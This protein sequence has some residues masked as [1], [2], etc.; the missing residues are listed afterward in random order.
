MAVYLKKKKFRGVRFLS[1]LD[2]NL[3]RVDRNLTRVDK[4]LSTPGFL[5]LIMVELWLF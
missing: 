2:R 1:T 3:T 5:V 4:N